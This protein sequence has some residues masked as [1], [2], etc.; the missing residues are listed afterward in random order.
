MSQASIEEVLTDT[1]FRSRES[2]EGVIDTKI[3]AFID[4]Q[5]ETIKKELLSKVEKEMLLMKENLTKI[6]RMPPLTPVININQEDVPWVKDSSNCEET[7][8]PLELALVERKTTLI[9]DKNIDNLL[10]GLKTLGEH[11]QYKTVKSIPLRIRDVLSL[12]PRSWLSGEILSVYGVILKEMTRKRS[13]SG[14]PTIHIEDCYFM[15]YLLKYYEEYLSGTVDNSRAGG[16]R[17]A[18]TVRKRL[19]PEILGYNPAEM[20][21]MIPLNENDHWTLAVIDP[22]KAAIYILDSI[23]SSDVLAKL[24]SKQITVMQTMLPVA[25][26]GRT[27]ARVEKKW[28][29]RTF[30]VNNVPKQQNTFDCG[31]FIIA[32]M[33]LIARGRPIHF[34]PTLGVTKRVICRDILTE[35]CAM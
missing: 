35:A 5:M 18:A 28:D 7:V 25:L 23:H 8:M 15:N 9:E 22:P 10:R 3:T 33:D 6:I 29:W 32:Y 21:I 20:L 16:S 13:K 1:E 12:S 14:K 4:R 2:L 27:E 11:Q 26:F 30:C 31:V 17:H 34:K 24:Y 19:N